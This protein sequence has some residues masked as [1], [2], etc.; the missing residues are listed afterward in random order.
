MIQ[1][2]GYYK[3]QRINALPEQNLT[4][5]TLTSCL[6]ATKCYHWSI[7]F[8]K[9]IDTSEITNMLRLPKI[10]LRSVL[11]LLLLITLVIGKYIEIDIN[12]TCHV[13]AANLNFV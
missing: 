9:L 4:F 11:A 8:D 1:T 6:I 10:S 7:E 3:F 12:Y 2:S 5:E 13:G